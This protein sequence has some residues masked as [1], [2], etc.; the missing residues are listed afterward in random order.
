M[1]K[2]LLTEFKKM[3]SKKNHKNY[4]LLNNC[5][6]LEKKAKYLVEETYEQYRDVSKKHYI[7]LIDHGQKSSWI[8]DVLNGSK[9]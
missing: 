9:E 1:N 8:F 7:D 2:K 3:Q 4:Y 6:D 5:G